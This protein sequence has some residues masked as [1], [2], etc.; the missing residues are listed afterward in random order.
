MTRDDAAAGLKKLD[1]VTRTTGDRQ[2]RLVRDC[3]A[4]LGWTKMSRKLG[5]AHLGAALEVAMA[6]QLGI[7]KAL[8]REIAGCT[9][10]L[11]EFLV[12]HGHW[13]HA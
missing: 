8:W 4:Y 1:P 7:R 6:Q 11:R 9:R 12:A 3:G 13:H 2:Y 5:T 10:G